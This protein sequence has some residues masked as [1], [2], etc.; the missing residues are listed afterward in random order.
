VDDARGEQIREMAGKFPLE[1]AGD[2][3]YDILNEARFCL[4]ASGT[5]TL[6]TALFNVPMIVMYKVN[7]L[8]Y[9]LAKLMVNVEAVSL[10]NI[11]SDRLI[12][13][14]YIQGDARAE[15][16]LPEAL[17]LIGDTKPRDTM[18]SE[19]TTLRGILGDSGASKKAAEEVLSVMDSK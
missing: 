17:E 2:Q 11:L 4:V 6:E 8:T 12:V 13:P 7:R 16:I 1:I 19:L 10:V 15:D 9:W 14:E 18:L 5:A 3:F